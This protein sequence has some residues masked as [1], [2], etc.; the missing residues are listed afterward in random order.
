MYKHTHTRRERKRDRERG[1]RFLYMEYGFHELKFTFHGHNTI[2]LFILCVNHYYNVKMKRHKR[3]HP[4]CLR[5][6]IYLFNLTEMRI[7][8]I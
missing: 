6:R 2:V 7:L 8:D 5:S 4:Y 1:S 3:M